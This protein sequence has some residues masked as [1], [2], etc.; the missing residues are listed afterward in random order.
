MEHVKLGVSL[1]AHLKLP[2]VRDTHDI[3]HFTE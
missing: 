3:P 2:M 1:V